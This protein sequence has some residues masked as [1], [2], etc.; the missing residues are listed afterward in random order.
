MFA[1]LLKS[2]PLYSNLGKFELSQIKA[3]ANVQSCVRLYPV[4]VSYEVCKC[5]LY[6]AILALS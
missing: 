3:R 5:L 6:V 2:N 4:V 1:T